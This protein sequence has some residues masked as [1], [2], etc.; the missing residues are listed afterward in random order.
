ML[1]SVR[2]YYPAVILTLIYCFA[3]A[4]R[5]IFNQL[6]D[7][8]KRD[9]GASDLE[10]SYLLGPA[11]I[12]SYVG[13]GLPAGWLV[14]RFNRSRLIILAGVIWGLGTM[15][16]ALADGYTGLFV[17]RLIVGASEAF[18]FPAGISLLPDIY[19]RKRLPIATSIFL[20][21]PAVGSALA[22]LGGGLVLDATDRLGTIEAPILGVAQ[23]WQLTLVVVGLVGIVPVLM[24]LGI[25]DRYRRPAD[26]PV[27][28]PA[29]EER[30]G[31]ISGAAYMIGR[32]RF[33]VC[34]F[35][36]M[37]CAYIAMT[38]IS[39]WAP[40]YLARTFGLTHGEIATRYGTIVLIFG[41]AGGMS[42]PA[43]SALLSR[44][45]D[46]PT[47]Q[48]VRLAPVMLVLFASLFAF[49]HTERMAL[50]CLAA[51]TFSYTFPMAMGST[52]MQFATPPRLRGLAAAYYFII[53]SLV[54]YGI[55]PSAV[56]L[57]TKYVL[58]D[59]TQIGLAIAIV[60]VAFGI[61]SFILFSI[62]ANGFRREIEAQVADDSSLR[63]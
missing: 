41:L 2:I 29:A 38:T 60:V 61:A 15:S 16:A 25:P 7:P 14:D 4:D 51:L 18:L 3:F 49:A 56:P 13:M 10:I 32:W 22:L 48:T 43:I 46:Y 50:A 33:Y 40:T 30:F 31:V 8:I 5:Q 17:S 59:E 55:G 63:A 53:T 62:A 26:G 54:G 35:V 12:F 36:G 42:A 45:A 34:F 11:F 57:L 6:V 39:A 23:G 44:V 19:D 9:F 20:L 24:M 1:R 47:M 37:A 21:A 28:E 27:G 58:H 52:S